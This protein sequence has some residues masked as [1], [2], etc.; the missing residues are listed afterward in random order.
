MGRDDRHRHAR[1]VF[2]HPLDQLQPEERDR[3]QLRVCDTSPARAT[4]TIA[5]ALDSSFEGFGDLLEFESSAMASL[6]ELSFGSIEEVF[7]ELE[8]LGY[9]QSDGIGGSFLV[10][11]AYLTAT[12][13]LAGWVSNELA[14]DD[15]AFV[16]FFREGRL[17][18]VGR[19][20]SPETERSSTDEAQNSPH[21][22]FRSRIRG[23]SLQIGR[24]GDL[25]AVA[26]SDGGLFASLTLRDRLAR[27]TQ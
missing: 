1:S 23:K 20:R 8:R 14:P 11:P 3:S 17:Q 25:W 18:S 5:D 26:I 2:L 4:G 24:D 6:L 15:P 7:R 22:R 19:T 9:R 16:V 13:H 21:L 12:T 10:R 27:P